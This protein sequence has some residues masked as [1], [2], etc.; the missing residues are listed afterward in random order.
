MTIPTTGVSPLAGTN[1]TLWKVGTNIP[2]TKV[3][4]QVFAKAASARTDT[5]TAQAN[6][7][8]VTSATLSF[9]TSYPSGPNS[10]PQFVADFSG[11]S[12]QS[13]SLAFTYP[14]AALTLEAVS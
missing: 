5:V 1:G 9:G 2:A 11:D 10:V 4:I 12:G 6:G 8:N 3:L 14:T 13:F 7:V